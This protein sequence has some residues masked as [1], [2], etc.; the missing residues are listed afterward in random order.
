MEISMR[1]WWSIGRDYWFALATLGTP[2]L[3][4]GKL[5]NYCESGRFRFLNKDI[6]AHYDQIEEQLWAVRNGLT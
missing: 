1:V 6:Y 2:L 3:I 5:A 4:N